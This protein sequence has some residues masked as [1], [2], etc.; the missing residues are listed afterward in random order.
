MGPASYPRLPSG[1][2][3]H[4]PEASLRLRGVQEALR[5]EFWRWG[6][7]PII[8]PLYEYLDVLERGLGEVRRQQIFKFVEPRTGEVVALRP[9]ITPQVARL[10]ATRYAGTEG[11]VRLSYEGRVVRFAR[12]SGTADA[13][14]EAEGREAPHEVFQV[15]VELLGSGGPEADAEVI[16]L[17][18][19]A[20]GAAGLA[21]FQIDLGHV[22]VTRGVLDAA[23]LP[24]EARRRVVRLVAK[25]DRSGLETLLGEWGAGP[26]VRRALVGLATLYG[27]EEVLAE[28]ERVLVPAAHAAL[29]ELREVVRLLNENG[30]GARISVDLGELRDFGYHDGALF[31]AYVPGLG[32]PVA[33]GG[34]Y[35]HLIE[36]YGVRAEATGFAVDVEQLL[37]ALDRERVEVPG[38]APA[39]FIV[40][41]RAL[42]VEAAR[43]LRGSGARAVC[44]LRAEP[45]AAA[46]RRGFDFVVQVSADGAEILRLADGGRARAALADLAR[47]LWELAP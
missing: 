39:A 44:A 46:R 7:Q 25:K 14:P 36:R 4:L 47:V 8:T 40:G 9:D 21:T 24:E 13:G 29:E 37:A 38:G 30:H 3:D 17:L 32:A 31:H 27:G 18:I 42:A 23:G 26:E 16:A 33:G 10:Y 15:G 2:Q 12:E 11:A 5:G 28:A 34:R 22:G 35:D 43:S 1:V 41:P 19:E 45:P 6:Y 20:L